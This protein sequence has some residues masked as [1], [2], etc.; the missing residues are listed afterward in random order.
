MTLT[1]ASWLEHRPRADKKYQYLRKI[2]FMEL[3]HYLPIAAYDEF[4]RA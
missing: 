3:Q 1:L 4:K 2:E